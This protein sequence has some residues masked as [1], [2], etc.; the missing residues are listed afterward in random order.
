MNFSDNQ[1]T[2][3]HIET[4]KYRLRKM[5]ISLTFRKLLLSRIA[6]NSVRPQNPENSCRIATMKMH[7]AKLCPCDRPIPL[8]GDVQ[9]FVVCLDGTRLKT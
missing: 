2:V 5:G 9:A 1:R 8:S 4:G 3:S 7:A 6:C